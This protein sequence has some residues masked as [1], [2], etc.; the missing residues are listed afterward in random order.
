VQSLTFRTPR[1]KASERQLV[2][3]SPATSSLEGMHPMPSYLA[4]LGDGF[5]APTREAWEIAYNL[6]AETMLEGAASARPIGR[7]PSRD[8]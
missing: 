8:R 3:V 2:H 5:D 4:V 1:P 7:L 6:V